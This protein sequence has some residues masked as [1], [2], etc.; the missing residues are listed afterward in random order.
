MKKLIFILT[1]IHFG[2][3]SNETLIGSN[4]EDIYV[5]NLY[6]FKYDKFWGYAD[7]YGNTIINPQF[8]EASL[9]HYGIAVVK[10]D[11]RFGYINNRGKWIVKPKYSSAELYKLRYHGLRNKD[12]THRKGLIARVTKDTDVLYINSDGKTLKNVSLSSSSGHG[13]IVNS[14]I[15]EYSVKNI[16]GTF[17][18]KYS[19]WKIENDTTGR[20]ILD[21]TQLKLDTII[22]VDDISILK[23]DSKYAIFS[24]ELL[25]GIDVIKNERTIIPEDSTYSIIP[26]FIYEDLKFKSING[27]EFPSWIFKKEGRWGLAGLGAEEIIPFIYFDITEEEHSP[28]YLVEFEEGKFG[29]ISIMLESIHVIKARKNKKSTTIIKEHFN[30]IK[31]SNNM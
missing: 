7:Y 20:K 26:K 28:S 15:D 13:V 3:K 25:R 23:K 16:D 14:N 19:Y 18:M 2:C 8:D 30:R 17:E 11:N 31:A 4:Y 6:P 29:Y 5:T 22:R 27:I 21:T 1:L 24:N 12:G 9:F 10:K